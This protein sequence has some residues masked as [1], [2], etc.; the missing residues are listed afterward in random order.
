MKDNKPFEG[1]ADPRGE[2][3]ALAHWLQQVLLETPDTTTPPTTLLFQQVLRADQLEL[4]FDSTYHL[5]FYQQLPDFIMALLTDE[6]QVM[7]RYAP[8][9][10]HLAGCRQCHAE[11]LDLYDALRA[12]V[13][14]QGPRPLLGQGTR[15]LKATPQRM[16]GH[17]CEVLISQAEALWYQARHE[18][19][20]TDAQA[21]VLLQLTL[22]MS[23]HI[24]QQ[25]IRRAALHDLVRVAAL[26]QQGAASPSSSAALTYTSTL[27]GMRGMRGI[28]GTGKKIVRRADMPLRPA[29]LSSEAAVIHL[30][31]RTL[32]GDIVQRGQ[33][34]ELHLRDLDQ[35]L[36]GHHVFISI[37]LGTLIEPV[38]WNG[39]NPHAIRS[40]EPVDAH[41]N[42]TTLLGETTLQLSNPEEYHLLEA[43]CMLV[44]VR[45]AA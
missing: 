26:F 28:G 18:H 29:D 33:L 22:H 11:H 17:L 1:N 9:L 23:V 24:A 6:A 45:K 7:Q 42:L 14:P 5:H 13:Q 20:D 12:A 2:Y 15:T 35:S 10:M 39:G 31:A 38:A 19:R 4:L 30:Q 40:T 36:R 44:E 27:S 37:L 41:G 25:S 43:L 8:L 16:L 32:E 21:R 3:L 34:L